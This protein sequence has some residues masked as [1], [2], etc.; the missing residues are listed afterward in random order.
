MDVVSAAD[1]VQ[2]LIINLQ[3]G[4]AAAVDDL[5]FVMPQHI[6]PDCGVLAAASSVHDQCSYWIGVGARRPL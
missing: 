2:I 3:A 6:Q 4:A 5:A 1:K